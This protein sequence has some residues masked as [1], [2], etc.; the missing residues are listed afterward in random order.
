M[1]VLIVD[2]EDSFVH[3]IEQA[4]SVH[5]VKVL[6]VRSRSPDDEAVAF[7]PDAIVLSPGPGARAI[8]SSPASPG[9][10]STVGR[11]NARS[12]GSAWAISLSPNAPAPAWS[13]RPS[14]STERPPASATTGRGLF[15]SVPSPLD[16]A[17]YHSLVVDPRSVPASFEVSAWGEGH[18]VMGL[19]HRIHPTESVQFHPESFLTPMGPRI[20][21]NFLEGARH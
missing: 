11:R 19:R 7:D 16:G 1:K 10:C 20:L 17:R 9:L 12:W 5:G 18:V 13:A 3:N 21:A 15:R 14:R 4:I 8:A 2:H 6:C